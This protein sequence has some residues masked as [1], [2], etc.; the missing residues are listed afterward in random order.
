MGIPTLES[1]IRASNDLTQI[2]TPS[3][4]TRV[5]VRS[6]DGP[7][8]E[9]PDTVLATPPAPIQIRLLDTLQ[10]LMEQMQGMA[11][12]MEQIEKGGLD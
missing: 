1:A 12:K 9:L 2:Q 3:K 7:E 11:E 5:T 8:D 10:C 4:E 6:V